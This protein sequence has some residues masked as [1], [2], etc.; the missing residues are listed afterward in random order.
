MDRFSFPRGRG[1]P[2]WTSTIF[3]GFAPFLMR[4]S[5]DLA[6]KGSRFADSEFR[7]VS[8]NDNIGME[9]KVM[10]ISANATSWTLQTLYG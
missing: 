9:R 1:G 2:L 5:D 7:A 4:I 10:V 8:V 6:F 3:G